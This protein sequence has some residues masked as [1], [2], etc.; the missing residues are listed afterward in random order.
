MPATKLI[1]HLEELP[2]FIIS[3]TFYSFNYTNR[4]LCGR[5][6]NNKPIKSHRKFQ[7]DEAITNR[8]DI[9][10]M[11]IC[12]NLSFICHHTIRHHTKFVASRVA[13]A[14]V[15]PGTF[16][17]PPT[18]KETASSR[19]APRHVRHVRVVMHVGIANQRWRGKRS[20]HSR[21]M[22]NPQFCESGKGPMDKLPGVWYDD[23]GEKLIVW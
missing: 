14:P 18:S 12:Q 1:A 9:Y 15:M 13:H 16:S 2:F 20:R 22:H 6:H 21:R 7:N 5:E 3:A 23:V 8:F 10:S 11:T 17:P 4:L 19:H